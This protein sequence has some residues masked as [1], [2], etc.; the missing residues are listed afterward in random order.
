VTYSRDLKL[1]PQ[2]KHYFHPWIWQ[3]KIYVSHEPLM[4]TLNIRYT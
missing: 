2:N 1:I 3:S 4:L